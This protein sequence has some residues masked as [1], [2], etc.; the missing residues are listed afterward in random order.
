LSGRIGDG[1]L[2][3]KTLLDGG[4]DL[5]E[6]VPVDMSA[7]QNKRMYDKWNENKCILIID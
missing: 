2:V 4:S 5:V 7:L 6:E 1:V 3:E